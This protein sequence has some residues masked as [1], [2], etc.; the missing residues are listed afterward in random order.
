MPVSSRRRLPLLMQAHFPPDAREVPP[1][2]VIAQQAAQVQH[3]AVQPCQFDC[4]LS[5]HVLC[6]FLFS[7]VKEL[8]PSFLHAHFG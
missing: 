8:L 7:W 1:I 2:F 3:H 6:S 5:F 4:L